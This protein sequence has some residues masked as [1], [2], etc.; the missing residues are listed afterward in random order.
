MSLAPTQRPLLPNPYSNADRKFINVIVET[1]RGCRNKFKYDETLRIFELKKVL[2]AGSAFPYD[3]G[4]VP[5]T[6]AQD[7]DPI[8]V[9]VL[10][11]E[12]AFTG[13]LIRRR[14]I[15]VLVARPTEHGTTV[16]NDR[17]VALAK[18]A[19]NYRDLRSLR[20]MNK[21]LLRELAHFFVSYNEMKNKKFELV[22]VKGP[23]F[24]RKLVNKSERQVSNGNGEKRK[25]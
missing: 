6:K 9:L 25:T 2:P 18:N 24:A 19:L 11:D 23:A 10:M 16:R 4:F 15:G 3:F 7:G 8:D 13:C 17:L 14:L 5:G 12:P 1:P 20:D 22:S 21:N